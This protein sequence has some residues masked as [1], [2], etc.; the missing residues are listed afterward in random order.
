M[1]IISSYIILAKHHLKYVFLLGI[2]GVK[3]YFKK[4]II[5][6]IT[7]FGLLTYSQII[8]AN[9]ALINTIRTII[10]NHVRQHENSHK[11]MKSHNG[12]R[13]NVHTSHIF[14]FINIISH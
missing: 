12:P 5:S 2:N 6:R 1:I 14:N 11:I 3:K 9:V 13:S 10:E 8:I 7:V 4:Y